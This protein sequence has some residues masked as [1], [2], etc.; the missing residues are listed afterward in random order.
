M[1][2]VDYI[3]VG[4]GLAG[5]S[6]SREL[7]KQGKSFIVYED[8]SQHSSKVAGG[9][10]NPIILKRFTP[11]WDAENQLKI[12]VP[13]YKELE[14]L[15]GATYDTKIPI[16]RLLTSIEE[17]NNWFA[18]CDHPVLSQYM[19]PKIIK[20]TFNGIKSPFGYGKVIGTG[21]IDTAKLIH[22]YRLYLEKK[23]VIIYSNFEYKAIQHSIKQVVYKNYIASKIVFCEGYGIKQNPY[24]NHLPMQEAK[25]EY[26]TIYAPD[27]HIDF[28]LKSSVS[29]M[30]LGGHTFKIGATFNWN[31]KTN[32][33]T[34]KGKDELVSKL[35]TLIS[36]PFEI[37]DQVAG[38]RPTVKDRRPLV[39]IHPNHTELAI[40]NGLGTRGVMIAP[41]VAKELYNHIEN[42][43]KL[44][45]EINIS[46]FTD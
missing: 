39:G 35:K 4:L 29:I 41:T 27:L 43:T 42:E 1:K 7:E 40:I 3:I 20:E 45:N 11:V 2:Q 19:I 18:T 44:R 31:D 36:V 9:M 26:I 13:F 15:L 25:G 6:F 14:N 33:P 10:Y 23:E 16:Y 34:E 46:R 12:A 32:I 17:Q 37:I 38:I 24:F 8:D 21:K 5:L 22:D 30:P 28:V